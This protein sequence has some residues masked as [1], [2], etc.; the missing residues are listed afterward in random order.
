MRVPMVS[1][2]V[3]VAALFGEIHGALAQSPITYPWCSKSPRGGS[4]S[5]RYTSYEQCRVTQ[6][7]LG[8]VCLQ[9]PYYQ[10]VP[11][12]TAVQPRS[13]RRG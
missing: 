2:L 8:G 3:L 6:S 12:K 13:Y 1:L 5:C 11:A 7:G 10:G 4:L 9:S